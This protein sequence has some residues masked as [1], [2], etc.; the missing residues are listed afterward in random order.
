MF[1]LAF[2]GYFD[3]KHAFIFILDWTINNTESTLA[4]FRNPIRSDQIRWVITVPTIWSN[5]AK[6]FMRSAA[7][8]VRN[9]MI[10]V[11]DMSDMRFESPTRVADSD[12]KLHSVLGP[13]DLV[14]HICD[15]PCD[16]S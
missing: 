15:F 7:H 3:F 16:F 10:P 8:K 12:R 13:P 6:Q 9:F 14:C 5:K 11:K 1:I 4:L 2:D